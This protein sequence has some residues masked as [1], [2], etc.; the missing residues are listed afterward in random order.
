MTRKAKRMFV[1]LVLASMLALAAVLITVLVHSIGVLI[2]IPFIEA[3]I[4]ALW[5]AKNVFFAEPSIEVNIYERNIASVPAAKKSIKQE[6]KNEV[7]NEP[8]GLKFLTL[9]KNPTGAF[10][11]K[12][13]QSD[14]TNPTS[15]TL[16]MN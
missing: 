11:R 9:F 6:F 4:Y 5:H 7:M 16:E 14:K 10:H 1:D 2:A 3:A 12:K 8:K 13:H 15:S